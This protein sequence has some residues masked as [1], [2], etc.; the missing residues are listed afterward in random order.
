MSLFPERASAS[1]RVKS[2]TFKHLCRCMLVIHKTHLKVFNVKVLMKT[3]EMEVCGLSSVFFQSCEL[4]KFSLYLDTTLTKWTNLKAASS[5]G[6]VL[7]PLRASGLLAD[8]AP[9]NRAFARHSDTA[10]CHQWKG[11]FLLSS[12]IPHTKLYVIQFISCERG[13]G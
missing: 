4:H 5:D 8:T 3:S 7:P 9:C 6:R 2:L 11:N 12:M 1:C 13:H 10:N